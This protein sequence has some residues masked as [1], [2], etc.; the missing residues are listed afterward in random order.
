MKILGIQF[1]KEEPTSIPLPELGMDFASV[2]NN[3]GGNGVYNRGSGDLGDPYVEMYRGE[4]PIYFGQDNLYPDHLNDLYNRSSLHSAIVDFKKELISGGGFELD[5]LEALSASEKLS[6]I[7]FRDYIDGEDSLQIVVS[8]LVMDYLIHGTMYMKLY[9]NSDKTKL[10]KA[11]RVEPSKIRVGVGTDYEKVSKYFY[12]FDWK[13]YGRYG[14]KE[15]PNFNYTSSAHIEI[16]RFVNPNPTVNW[17]TLPSYSSAANWVDLDGDV[18][19]YHKSNIE[20]SVNPSMA[21][22]F[23]ERPASEEEK[24]KILNGIK[25][26]AQGAKN[27]GRSMVFFADGKDNLPEIETITVSN[28]DKQFNV[29]SDHIQRNICYSHRINPLILG[30]KTPGSL[31]NGAELDYA[32]E[33]FTKSVIHPAQ[34]DIEGFINKILKLKGLPVKFVFNDNEL[35]S[36]KEIEQ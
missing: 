6:L 19:L 25:R 11:E 16:I 36:K 23:P 15:I 5:G 10:L 18:S 13:E 28:I 24:R 8:K 31:G 30:F 2:N 35:Y 14:M 9:W 26:Q 22:K 1:G 4:G 12:S 32:Y 20:N 7:Q 21:I 17:Y 29:T 34:K 3:W 33:I 27:A